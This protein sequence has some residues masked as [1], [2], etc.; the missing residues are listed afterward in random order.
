M[1]TA[2]VLY[3]KIREFASYP[4]AI[5]FD[6]EYVEKMSQCDGVNYVELPYETACHIYDN[7]LEVLQ[8][9]KENDL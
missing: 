8:Y 7:K 6:I 2:F 3:R 1:K 4:F 9:V 5:D